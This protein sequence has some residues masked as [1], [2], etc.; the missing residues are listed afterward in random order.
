MRISYTELE[1]K[2]C[3]MIKRKRFD[4][5]LG[6]AYVSSELAKRFGLS[7]EDARYIG[8]Y[9]DAYR[10][11][12]DGTSPDYCRAHGVEV[13][14]EEE[15]NVMLL[16]G[17]LAAIHFPEDA[18]DVPEYFQRAVRHHTL[19]HVEMGLYGAVLYIADYTEPGR[20]HLTDKDREEIFSSDSLEE[21]IIKIMDAQRAYF[22]S[23]GT[24]E[25]AVSVELYNA[26]KSGLRFKV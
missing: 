15:A 20:K 22:E 19:G 23:N 5:S 6:V 21:M 14:P 26:L 7:V 11:A 16:H 12:F 9:H 13:F 3:L 25:A 8:I 17:A 4:H 18:G 2:V 1:S 10:Y 24:V